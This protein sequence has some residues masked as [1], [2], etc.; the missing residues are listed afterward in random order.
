M[1]IDSCQKYFDFCI[2]DN[3]E[4]FFLNCQEIPVK[5]FLQFDSF[6]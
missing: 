2:C 6:L 4:K 5:L 3:N 1:C